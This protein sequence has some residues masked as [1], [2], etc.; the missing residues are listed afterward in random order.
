MRRFFNY[1][2]YVCYL[3]FFNI[4]FIF[5]PVIQSFSHFRGDVLRN[6]NPFK[7]KKKRL[8]PYMVY[9]AVLAFPCSLGILWLIHTF[10]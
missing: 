7:K 10:L 1:F 4:C 9:V 2:F 3:L 5:N 8:G 6:K